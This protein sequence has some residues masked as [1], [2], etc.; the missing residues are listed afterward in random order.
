MTSRTDEWRGELVVWIGIAV[1]MTAAFG[2]GR[3]LTSA[4]IVGGW[5]LLV[6]GLVHFGR[7]RIDAVRIVGGAGDERNRDLYTRVNA[8]AGTVLWAVITSWWLVTV[9]RGEHDPKLSAL[10]LIH[11]ASCAASAVYYAHRG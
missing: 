4:L 3:G 9:F 6:I 8:F 5:M 1:V 2:I 7:S 11:A 10:V